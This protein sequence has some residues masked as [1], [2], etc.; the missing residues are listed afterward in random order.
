MYGGYSVDKDVSNK[1]GIR[2]LKSGVLAK[3][4]EFYTRAVHIY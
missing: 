4:T 1:H 3:E 2:P